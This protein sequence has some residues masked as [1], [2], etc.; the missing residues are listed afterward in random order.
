MT[1]EKYTQPAFSFWGSQ[2]PFDWSTKNMLL[3]LALIFPGEMKCCMRF[4]KCRISALVWCGWCAAQVAGCRPLESVCV[5]AYWFVVIPSRSCFRQHHGISVVTRESYRSVW[6]MM[7]IYKCCQET[8]YLAYRNNEHKVQ[9]WQRFL[10]VSNSKS[11]I[12]GNCQSKYDGMRVKFIPALSENS[13]T[14]EPL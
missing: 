12:A 11:C 9:E 2:K 13:R 1:L 6:C 10:D 4:T 5:Y 3:P 7:P 14:S 8:W